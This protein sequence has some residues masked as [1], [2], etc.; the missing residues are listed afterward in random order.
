MG[1]GSL[2][3]FSHLQILQAIRSLNLTLEQINNFKDTKVCLKLLNSLGIKRALGKV[4]KRRLRKLWIKTLR[5]QY[6]CREF[7]IIVERIE[8][9]DVAPSQTT[10]QQ[11]TPQQS[12]LQQ[13]TSQQTTPQQTT[14]QQ[15][16]PPPATPQ[17]ATPPHTTAQKTTKKA[18]II[19]KKTIKSENIRSHGDCDILLFNGKIRQL[20]FNMKP[21]VLNQLLKREIRILLYKHKITCPVTFRHCDRTF[22]GNGR[23]LRGYC[24]SKEYSKKDCP[25]EHDRRF[26]AVVTEKNLEV[27]V[28]SNVGKEIQHKFITP[29]YVRGLER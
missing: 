5:K 10:P 24:I 7:R 1:R 12:K 28:K 9:S 20:D 8:V 13:S 23:K 27:M 6:V 16:T 11:T 18:P 22:D 3:S 17:Q 14:A 2:Y 25:Y 26:V 29:R 21:L 19:K 4:E 15:S